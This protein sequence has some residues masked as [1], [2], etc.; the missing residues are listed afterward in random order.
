MKSSSLSVTIDTTAPDA[1][2]AVD[3]I[4]ASDTGDSTTDNITKVT[5]PTFTGKAE[6]GT[7][8]T[9]PVRLDRLTF[10]ASDD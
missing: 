10:V 9:L 5:T 2:T 8:V 1:P 7:T 3:M 6:I 4:V